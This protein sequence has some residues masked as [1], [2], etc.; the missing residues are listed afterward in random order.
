MVIKLQIENV[1]MQEEIRLL[2]SQ[3]AE[4]FSETSD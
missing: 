3:L 4:F 2:K 1:E